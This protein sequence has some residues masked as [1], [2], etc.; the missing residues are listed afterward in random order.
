MKHDSPYITASNLITQT[1]EMMKSTLEI[2]ITLGPQDILCVIGPRSSG[3]TTLIKTLVGLI[4]P[5]RGVIKFF[6]QTPS[7]LTTS[8]WQTLRRRL[9]YINSESSLLSDKSGLHNLMLPALYHNLD[10]RENIKNKAKKII[11]SI[12]PG[13]LLSKLVPY[14]SLEQRCKLVI[15]RGLMLNPEVM[16]LD[17][18]F[19]GLHHLSIDDLEKFL[20]Q[21]VRS[22]NMALI[23]GTHKINFVK[24]YATK[25]IFISKAAIGYFESYEAL[26]NSDLPSIRGFLARNQD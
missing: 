13:L 17:E 2:N 22:S 19:K 6:E 26:A 18:A 16:C 8:D 4:P 5:E 9:V 10:S 14:L 1:R 23:L 7:Q 15:C 12:D 24:K 21:H 11:Q 25:I 3:K 20:V